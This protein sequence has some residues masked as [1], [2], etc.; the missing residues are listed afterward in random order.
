MGL[1]LS[2]SELVGVII[3]I[4]IAGMLIF[5]LSSCISNYFEEKEKAQAEGILERISYVMEDLQLNDQNSF[6]IYSPKGYY[7]TEIG[8]QI[9][10]CDKSDCSNKNKKYCKEIQKEVI[11]EGQAIKID[12]STVIIQNLKNNYEIFKV[13]DQEEESDSGAVIAYCYGNL[14]DIGNGFQLKESAA[15]KFE[16]AKK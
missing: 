12:P 2:R 5:P 10:I 14:V 3:A 8:N 16:L 7:L 11:I 4:V 13:I 9:C 15:E 1:E 6:F